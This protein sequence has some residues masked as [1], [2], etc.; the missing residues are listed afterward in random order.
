MKAAIINKPWGWEEVWAQTEDYV[1]KILHIDKGQRL[2]LQFHVDK[3]E[4]IRVLSGKLEVFYSERRDG[5]IKSLIL[6]EG[7]VFHVS[8]LTVHRFCATQGTDVEILEVS[9]NHLDDVTRLEDDYQR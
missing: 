3:E 4:T 6:E 7:G 1:G 5:Q 2:S 8:P 9:T